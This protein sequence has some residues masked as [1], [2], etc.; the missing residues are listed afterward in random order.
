MDYEDFLEDFVRF[1]AQLEP[2]DLSRTAFLDELRKLGRS[3]AADDLAA[4]SDPTFSFERSA[5]VAA[6]PV[7]EQRLHHL[8]ELARE[9]EPAAEP[10]YRVFKREVPLSQ[11]I[12]AGSQPEWAVGATLERTIGPIA[13]QDGRRFW[14]DLFPII[15]LV[16]LYLPGEQD[17]ALLFFVS[18]TSRPTGRGSAPVEG[19]ISRFRQATYTLEA[20]SLWVRADLLAADAPPKSY[21]GLRIQSGQIVLSQPPQNI[22]GKLTI[23]HGATCSLSLQL[24][25]SPETN[26][27]RPTNDAASAKLQLPRNFSFHF[28]QQERAID[29]VGRSGWMLYGQQLT[30]EWDGQQHPRYD[31]TLKGV[32]IALNSRSDELSAQTSRSPFAQVSGSAV[33]QQAAWL[34]PVA[35]I[36]VNQPTA[37]GGNGGLAVQ[38]NSTLSLT[39]RGLRNGPVFLPQPWIVLFPGLLLIVDLQASNL[40]ATQRFYLWQD[41]DSPY[42]SSVEIQYADSFPLFYAAND[43]GAELVL[44]QVDAEAKLDRPVDAG[45]D[46]LEIR[47]KNSLLFLSYTEA[48][49]L[50]YLYDD[51][52]LADNLNPN[53]SSV[54]QLPEPIALA[55]RNALFTTTPVNGFL[56]FAQLLDEEMVA[57]GNVLLVFGLYG[58]LPTLPDPYAANVGIFRRLTDRTP[59]RGGIS[60]LLWCQIKWKKADEDNADTVETNFALLPVGSAAAN[61]LASGQASDMSATGAPAA[62]ASSAAPFRE[63]QWEQEWDRRFRRFYQEQFALLDV[64]TNADWMGVS[65]GWFDPQTVSDNDYVFYQVYG[66]QQAGDQTQNLFPLQVQ[67]LDLTAEGRFVRAFTVPQISWE[68]LVN[69]TPPQVPG[70]PPSL[71]NF[72]PNDGGPTRLLNDNQERVPIAPLPKVEELLRYFN[73]TPSGFTGALFTLAF[74][75]KAFAEFTKNHAYLPDAGLKLNQENFRDDTLTGALQIQADAPERSTESPMFVGGT[76]QLNNIV[77][78]NGTPTGASTLG[79]S[80]SEIFNNEFFTLTGGYGN[81]GVPLERIDFSGYGSSTFSH[82][83]NPEAAFAQTSQA[84]FDVFIGRTAHE[85]IQVRSVI[86]PWGIRVVRTIVIFRAGSSYVYRFDTGWQA[87]TPGLYDFSYRVKESP[88]AQ[89]VLRP[90]PFEF[91]PGVVNGVFNVRNIIET[92]AIPQFERIWNKVNGD[93]YIDDAGVEQVVDNVTPAVFRN[94]TVKLQPVYFDADVEIE[95][96]E[97]GAVNGKVP[98]KGMLGYV[99]LSPAGQPIPDFL[100]RDLLREQFGSLGGLVD[101]LIDIGDTGQQMRITRVDVSESVNAAGNKPLFVSTAR[102]SVVLP[103]DGA[104]SVVQ[105]QHGSG[106]VS[107]LPDDAT[108]PLI[109]QGVLGGASTAPLRLEN[110]M[111]LVRSST[112]SSI[113]FGLLQSTGTQKAMFRKPRFEEGLQ[114]LL[115]EAPDFADAYRMLNSVGIFPNLQDAIP[116]DLGTYKTRI[117]EEGYKLLDEANPEKLFE[118]ALPDGP[119]YIINEDFLKLYIE[120]DK[121]DKNGAKQS[122]G[123]INFGIDSA[124]QEMGNRWLSKL[125]NVGMVVDLG[126]LTRLMIIKGKFDAEKGAAPSF[127]GPELEFGDA[128]QPVIDILQILLM[129]QGGDY[130]DALAKGL[131]IAMSNSTDSWEYAFHA[132]KEIPL[133]RF[134]PPAAD[135]PTAPL[136]LECS[137]AVGVYFNEVFPL[138]DNP[139]QLIPSAGAFL[140]FYGRLSVMCVSVAAAT[141]YATGSVDLRIAADIKTG[142]SLMMKFGFGAEINVGLPVIGTVSLLYMVGVEIILDS[143]KVVV[144][145]FL[146]FRGRAEILGGIV[147]VTIFIEAKGMVERLPGPGVTNMIAQVT[148]GL[149]ISVFLVINI[150][151]TKSWQ[152]SRQIA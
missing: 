50:V 18:S 113:F 128:L 115:S 125:N 75:L 92:A 130:A 16:P 150:K 137:L 52:I 81:R 20:G 131:E 129:L 78:P 83:E 149:H 21:I 66:A 79:S 123:F 6:R 121:R 120:Y 31:A 2:D 103:K 34:L 30:F 111:E 145:G 47:S 102:G 143:S 61:L 139:N 7:D 13:S 35:V 87:E 22:Q 32:L 37:A 95:F 133:V 55:L 88:V 132:R 99:Q 116:L 68:P 135:S 54:G 73:E 39:W 29:V 80:V 5:G 67:G 11:A 105:Y 38:G 70:D 53:P 49:Q 44:A 101:G 84:R 114:E 148:F 97:S 104:W 46:A 33:I 82:W 141:I 146:L 147:T 19:V 94:P 60:M 142:P 110:P 48:Q 112:P 122:D 107:P 14:F 65:M 9:M 96:I 74:G 15:P 10:A 126:P 98:S 69:L 119:W 24:S 140:E 91:H 8:R 118:K 90:N 41:A 28:S 57:A 63:Q 76:L 134:P 77:L 127:Q 71:F 3:L 56:L 100:F 27:S 51:N 36:D 59:G 12:I 17:P 58:L 42:R 138:T 1:M 4:L 89:P 40:Y 62:R 124:A 72:F 64:S 45:G 136:K 43:Q 108:V 144:A 23:P 86:Y 93:T 109:R 117:I 106:E 26:A 25:P 152:E 85:V 151:F